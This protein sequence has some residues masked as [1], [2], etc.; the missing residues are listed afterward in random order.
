MPTASR[1]PDTALAV[2]LAFLKL[3]CSAFG[4]PIAHLGYFRDEFVRRRGWLSESSYADLVA[5]CQ[6]LP[7]P[8]SSQ[9]G[10]ALGLA[11]AGYPGALAAWLGFT[12]PS[13]LLLVLFALG[14]GRWGAL[15][16]E[17]VLHGLKIAAVAVVAQAVWGMGRSL[18][19]D[20]PRLALMA[21]SLSLIHISE[22]TRLQLIS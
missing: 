21:L 14:L 13:A 22:P 6:F 8:A 17:G 4:G 20:R 12:L 16:P 9:V 18:C 15:L 3:G 19:P 5:L 1:H 11:R 10:M 7:G 2:F